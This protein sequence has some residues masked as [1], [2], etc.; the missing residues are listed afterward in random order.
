MARRV[1]VEQFNGD[2]FDSTKLTFTTEIYDKFKAVVE[3]HIQAK[4]TEVRL[5]SQHEIRLYSQ[6]FCFIYEEFLV[7]Y[8]SFSGI[9]DMY[10]VII[11]NSLISRDV[12]K[13]W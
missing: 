9:S 4:L 2:S 7:L 6:R 8:K 11:I 1:F 5:Y 12:T 3:E 10:S 13:V